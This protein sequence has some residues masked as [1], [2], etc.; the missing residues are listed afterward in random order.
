MH[1]H[2]FLPMHLI[3]FLYFSNHTFHLSHFTML[4]LMNFTSSSSSAAADASPHALDKIR[5]SNTD[6]KNDNQ[7]L[8]SC[9][10]IK[11]TC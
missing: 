10:Q 4:D 5:Y 7:N 3:Q 8:Y 1:K 11:Y 2:H 6:T 9:I